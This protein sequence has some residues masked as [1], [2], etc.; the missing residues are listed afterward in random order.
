MLWYLH[1]II[2]CPVVQ[3]LLATYPEII[4]RGRGRQTAINKA[5]LANNLSSGS[6][7]TQLHTVRRSS[8]CI[9]FS[10]A[11]RTTFYVVDI[12]YVPPPYSRFTSE[13]KTAAQVEDCLFQQEV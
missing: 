12:I 1:V 3:L 7:T 10:R 11:C 8:L 5:L 6:M 2:S 9:K 13:N 4:L